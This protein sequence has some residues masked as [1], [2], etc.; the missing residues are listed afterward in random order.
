MS[1]NGGGR[2]FAIPT[3]ANDIYRV[4]L[5]TG[6]DRVSLKP[7]SPSRLRWDD[8]TWEGGTAGTPTEYYTEG[9]YI[10]FEK[11]PRNIS[12]WV[13]ATAY[14]LG[15]Q[16]VPSGTNQEGFIYSCITAGTSAAAGD[17]ITWP[18]TINGTATDNT[19]QWQQSGSVRVWLRTLKEPTALSSG[20]SAPE[21][22]PQRY[23]RTIARGAALE[24]LGGFDAENQAADKRLRKLFIDYTSDVRELTNLGRNRSREYTARIKVRFKN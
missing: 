6:T 11:K 17:Q 13:A 23:H 14:S 16:V 3:S 4:R 15:D 24:L 20:G 5:G 10:G 9:P 7:M 2:E 22:L 8:K 21:W 18:V 1:I 12:D 19:A